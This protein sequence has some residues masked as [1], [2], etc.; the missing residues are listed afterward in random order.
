MQRPAEPRRQHR[1]S[2]EGFVRRRL[3]STKRSAHEHSTPSSC[4]PARRAARPACAPGRDA[5]E[6]TSACSVRVS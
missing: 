3:G 5:S 6:R 2:F 4:S 1:G